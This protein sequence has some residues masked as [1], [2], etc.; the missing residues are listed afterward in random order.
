M[1]KRIILLIIFSLILIADILLYFEVYKKDEEVDNEINVN[2]VTIKD[3]VFE[4]DSK[5]LIS[6]VL[7]LDIDGYLDTEK[8][9]T[10]S[11]TIT[12][13]DKDYIINY[14]VVDT[15]APIIMGSSTKKT[16]IGEK[17][18]LVNKYLCGDN[19]DSKPK[20]RIEGDYDINSKG[21]YKLTYVA[22]DT[23]GN[24]TTKSIKLKVIEKPTNTGSNSSSS[25]S[26]SSIKTTK[27]SKYI[28]KHKKENTKIGI[29]VSAWQ[30]DIDWKKAKKD[31]VE[32]AI[33]RIGFGHTNSNEL[34]LDK[35][36]KNNLKKTKELN[37]PIGLYFYSYAKT[38][39]QAR[40]QAKWIVKELN[41]QKLDLPIAFDWENWNSFNKYNVS[42]KELSDIADTFIEEVE[43]NGY[44]GMLYSSAYYLNHMW[45]DFDN[46]WVAYYTENNDFKK[47]YIMW[48][49]SSKGK[50]DG[51]TGPV[52]IDILY[53]NKNEH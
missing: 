23:S 53:E 14:E 39:E 25:S 44:K 16:Y 48:Q 43:N 7:E 28:K 9:G 18:N 24:K 26:T 15:T 45:R 21:T 12:H 34:V 52:D 3:L 47:P 8:L 29:D 37:I 10:N 33:L 6:D 2:I 42:F 4:Y 32:F 35:W 46:T 20:C 31:G 11:R 51:I 50:V 27:L 5:V 49:L 41:G 30:D 40:E 22:E 1:K 19:H 13:E 17:I 38:K 36:F